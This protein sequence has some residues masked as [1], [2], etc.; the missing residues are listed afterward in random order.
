MIIMGTRHEFCIECGDIALPRYSRCKKCHRE[1]KNKRQREKYKI[2]EEY[3][4]RKRD[5]VK[6]SQQKRQDN[7]PGLFAKKQ[8]E[9]RKNNPDKFNMIMAKTFIRKL[10]AD[11]KKEIVAELLKE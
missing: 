6:K 11:Q 7:N 2:D 10:N 5:Q 8:R 1:R 4:K 9:F 3:N